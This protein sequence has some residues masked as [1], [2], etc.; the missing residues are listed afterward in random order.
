VHALEARFGVGGLVHFDD[1]QA[2]N[3]GYTGQT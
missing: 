2:G 3:E 1:H